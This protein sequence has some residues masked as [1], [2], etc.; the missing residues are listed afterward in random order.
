MAANQQNKAEKKAEQTE[1]KAVA[2]QQDQKQQ[3]ADKI[4]AE[5]SDIAVD[6]GI[7]KFSTNIGVQLILKMNQ[8]LVTLTDSSA[9]LQ[10]FRVIIAFLDYGEDYLPQM[11]AD[12]GTLSVLWFGLDKRNW[13]GECVKQATI[14][15]RKFAKNGTIISSMY[16]GN[17]DFMINWWFRFSLTD[18]ASWETSANFLSIIDNVLIYL[19][20]K[21]LV[22][23]L[24]AAICDGIHCKINDY[25]KWVKNQQQQETMDE[26]KNDNDEQDSIIDSL[27]VALSKLL[28]TVVQRFCLDPAAGSQV[29]ILLLA[30]FKIQF[31]QKIDTIMYLSES[32]GCG[33]TMFNNNADYRDYAIIIWNGI[34]TMLSNTKISLLCKSTLLFGVQRFVEDA[35]C[36]TLV[37]QLINTQ[38]LESL[39][40]KWRLSVIVGKLVDVNCFVEMCIILVWKL[41]RHC[42][43]GPNCASVW[44]W[45]ADLIENGNKE[46]VL[47]ALKLVEAKIIYNP[48]VGNDDPL[49]SSGIWDALLKRAQDFDGNMLVL[50]IIQS[51][52]IFKICAP[53]MNVDK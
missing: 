38:Q 30:Q 18:F 3:M 52:G 51:L 28:T 11:M 1:H 17:V 16:A 45:I 50:T 36:G 49:V 41:L 26:C 8:K 33:M 27:L 48:P 21:E 14:I 46:I 44:T 20:N 43:F 9:L 39:M 7:S 4:D 22:Y 40:T 37:P 13:D 10:V 35:K 24:C 19:K 47:S 12:N 53:F 29:F 2:G 32:I 42:N 6:W 23:K 15:L 31:N 5:L 25:H 34:F